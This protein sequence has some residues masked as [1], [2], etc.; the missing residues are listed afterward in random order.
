MTENW[1]Q[2]W[3]QSHSAFSFFY[4]PSDKKTYRMVIKSAISGKKV[5]FELSNECARNDVKIGEITVALCDEKGSFLSDCKNVSVNGNKSYVLKKGEVL[6]S[7]EAELQIGAGEYFCISIYV[8]KGHLRSGNLLSDVELITAK[9][10]VTKKPDVPNERRTRDTVREKASDILR[11]YFHKPIPIFQSVQVLN[12]TG[13]QTIAV[14]GDSIS[15]QGYWVNAFRERINEKF[16]EQYTV[17]N[18][19]IMGNRLLKNYNKRFICK[20]LFG[21]GGLNRLQRDIL[22]YDDVKYVLFSLG[23]NDFIQYATLAAPKAEKPTVEEMLEGMKLVADKLHRAGKKIIV[24]NLFD[25][26]DFGDATPE[27]SELADEYNKLLESNKA[28]FDGFYDQRSLYSDPD[29]PLCSKH[30]FL[31][32][33]L[34]HP[35]ELGGKIVAQNLDLTFL[36]E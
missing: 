16:P 26:G 22:D 13:A 23:I 6:T 17:V 20:G 3:A 9:G 27:K 19:S 28:W 1:V 25:F 11:M 7:D 29:R 15:Q 36:K 33:D 32:K 8:E 4:Y 35:N 12:D 21:T 34:L 31:G 2:V 14:F 5:R 24:F 10:N 30:E 18:K